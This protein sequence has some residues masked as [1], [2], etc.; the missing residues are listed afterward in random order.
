MN[1]DLASL[2]KILKDQTRRK[3]VQ[4]LNGKGQLTYMELMNLLEITNT[5]KFNYHL[6]ILAD[7]IQKEEDGR[8]SLTERGQLASQLLQK[9]PEK[10]KAKPLAIGDALLIG[11]T[12]FFLVFS[13]T[14]VF[15]AG[16]AVP[17]FL[18]TLYELFV[19]GPVMWW[20]TVKRT[21]SHDFY[22]LFK[23]ALVPIALVIAWIVLMT[24]T[25]TWFSLTW[26]YSTNNGV[27]FAIVGLLSFVLMSAYPFIGIT[28]A[29]FLYRQFKRM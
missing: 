29:E 25:R 17:V 24:L 28:L 23:P 8:Y 1:V 10:P 13:L 12:G 6:K 16:F 7:L 9:F 2:H 27:L 4:Y 15:L 20:L 21:K 18:V 22:D 19:P 11:V 26:S 5:G 14:L 3:I